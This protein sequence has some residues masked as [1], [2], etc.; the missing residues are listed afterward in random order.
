MN[1]IYPENGHSWSSHALKNTLKFPVYAYKKAPLR[2][3]PI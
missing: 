3:D 1:N 2:G